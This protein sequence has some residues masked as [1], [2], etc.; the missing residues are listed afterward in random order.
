[1]IVV[2]LT[3]EEWEP[4]EATKYFAQL[5]PQGDFAFGATEEAALAALMEKLKCEKRS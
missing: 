2:D 4:T 5:L 1:M 3:S